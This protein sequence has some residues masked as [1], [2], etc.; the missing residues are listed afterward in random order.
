MAQRKKPQSSYRRPPKNVVRG[1]PRRR[2][3]RYSRQGQRNGVLVIIVG[4][5]VAITGIAVANAFSSGSKTQPT[6]AEATQLPTPAATSATPS[7]T[8]TPKATQSATPKATTAPP[9]TAAPTPKVTKDAHTAEPVATH[10]STPKASATCPPAAQRVSRARGTL[11]HPST[12]PQ[13]SLVTA[14]PRGDTLATADIGSRTITLY[15]QPC[16]SEPMQ[17]LAVAWMYEAGQFIDIEGWDDSTKARWRQL[18]GA[19]LPSNLELRRDAASV[20]AYWQ[21]GTTQGWQSPVSPPSPSRLA[22]LA[23]FLRFG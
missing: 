12:L 21:T 22:E 8:A 11:A 23:T 19:S 15:L 3:S 14:G 4:L 2:R 1:K 16:S 5:F 13:V 10:K 18:R 7:H 17:R 6:A 9:K 20:F